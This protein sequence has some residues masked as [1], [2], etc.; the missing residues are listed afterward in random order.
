MPR[1]PRKSPRDPGSD[2]DQRQRFIETARELGC[3]EDGAAFG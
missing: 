1:T 3:E 2:A